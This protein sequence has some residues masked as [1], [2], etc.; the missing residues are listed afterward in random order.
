MR[1][2]DRSIVSR[3]AAAIRDRGRLTV[4]HVVGE[5]DDEAGFRFRGARDEG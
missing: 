4:P 1:R 2:R 5:Q 3:E